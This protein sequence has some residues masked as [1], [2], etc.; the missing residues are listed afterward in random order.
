MESILAI[1]AFLYWYSYSVTHWAQDAVESAIR[2]GAD[3]P[4]QA[5]GFVGLAVMFLHPLTWVII[6]F[7][8]EGAVRFLAGAFTAKSMARSRSSFWT[9]SL[10]GSLLAR[11]TNIRRKQKRAGRH[12]LTPFDSASGFYGFQFC[13]TKS[14]Q[15]KMPAATYC[16]SGRRAPNPAGTLRASCLATMFTID[17]NVFPNSPDQDLTSISCVACLPESQVVP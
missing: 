5:V 7:G 8:I 6:Y 13:R 12:F 17:S 2:S 9:N 11:P 15:P 4:P 14:S 16:R 10:C 1:V 3:I